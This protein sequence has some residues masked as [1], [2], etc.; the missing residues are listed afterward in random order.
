MNDETTTTD[1]IKEKLAQV[2]AEFSAYVG[3]KY[4]RVKKTPLTGKPAQ[5]NQYI[6]VVVLGMRATAQSARERYAFVVKSLDGA[7]ECWLAS[8]RSFTLGDKNDP[9][10]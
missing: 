8:R 7:G 9:P 4:I 6:P 10:S 1:T 2:G 3:G 5:L